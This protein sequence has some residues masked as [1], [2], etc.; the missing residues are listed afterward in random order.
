MDLSGKYLEEHVDLAND[1]NVSI[2]ILKTLVKDKS[3]YV[4]YSVAKNKNVTEELLE[5][6][7]YDESLFVLAA[8]ISSDKVTPE[9]IARLN[10]IPDES[11]KRMLNNKRRE[12]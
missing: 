12:F 11:I 1:P 9:I 7:S 2:D 4:R 10:Q 6:L 5:L 3:F 8:V